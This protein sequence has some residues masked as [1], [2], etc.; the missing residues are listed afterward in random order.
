MD[1][2]KNVQKMLGPVP[3]DG[4]AVAM[5]P[6]V[7]SYFRQ[8]LPANSAVELA[9]SIGAVHFVLHPMVCAIQDS[10]STVQNS[11]P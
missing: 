4:V 8:Q 2:V 5:V 3:L 1:Y 9:M 10:V 6:I 7:Y 11:L